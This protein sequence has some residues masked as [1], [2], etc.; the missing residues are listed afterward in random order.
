MKIFK[1]AHT[2]Y[3][4]VIIFVFFYFFY[5]FNRYAF[6]NNKEIPYLI[7]FGFGIIIIVLFIIT[8]NL[9]SLLNDENKSYYR[10]I[11]NENFIKNLLF[12]LMILTIF[13]PPVSFSDTIIGWN[14]ISVLNYF[15]GFTILFGSAFIPGICIYNLTPNPKIHELFNINPLIIKLSIYPLISFT[16]L[17]AISLI[18]DR[19]GLLAENFE[20]V[21]FLIIFFLFLL[22]FLKRR[23]KSNKVVKNK[24]LIK[25]N[26]WLLFMI[27]FGCTI[28]ALG[29]HISSQY[30]VPGDSWNAVV[31]AN[32]IGKGAPA[33]DGSAYYIYWGYIT[34]SL[35]ILTGIPY[36]NINVMLIS[37]IYLFV[38]LVYILIK[39]I[40]TNY[41]DI[42]AILA[43][44]FVITYSGL[45][46][47]YNSDLETTSWLIFD[48]I[49]NF[50]YKSFSVN[51]FLFSLSLFIV[52]IKNYQKFDK[53][54]NQK[55]N[56][57]IIFFV[58]FF[59][60][61]SYMIY[62]IPL[63][64]EIIFIVLF[65][66][67][68]KH[69]KNFEYV[70]LFLFSITVLFTF[71][72]F[73][74]YF[75]FSWKAITLTS[76][77]L[78]IPLYA[79]AELEITRRFLTGIYSNLFLI[80]IFILF[81]C[82][83]FIYKRRNNSKNYYQKKFIH[84][85]KVNKILGYSG[86]LIFILSLCIEL[87]YIL[88]YEIPS[89]ILIEP[90]FLYFFV[91]V[92][93][94]NIGIAGIFGLILSV[95]TFR[96][97][98][99]IFQILFVWL[100]LIFLVSSSLIFLNWIKYPLNPPLEI[101][102]SEYGLMM[103][104]FERNWYY[105]IIPISIFLSIGL[106]N[107]K[108]VISEKRIK[109]YF[110]FDIDLIQKITS[111]ILISTLIFFTFTN[112][113]IS[114]IYWYNR[115]NASYI[116]N[117]EAQ[118]YGYLTKNVP[119]HSNIVSD[120][121]KIVNRLN[122]LQ[123]WRTYYIYDQ[124]ENMNNKEI[125]FSYNADKNC[126]LEILE[127]FSGRNNIIYMY[128]NNDDGSISLQILFNSSRFYGSIELLI[129]PTDNNTIL[130][131]GPSDWSFD[132]INLMSGYFRYW[133][134]SDYIILQSYEPF[135]WY[136]I[137]IDFEYSNYG[138]KGLSQYK[139]QVT[140]NNSV[141]SNLN[142]IKNPESI[143]GFRIETNNLHVDESYYI[144]LINFS[145]CTNFDIYEILKSFD[146]WLIETLVRQ[147]IHYFIHQV[148]IEKFNEI[149][150]QYFNKTLYEYGEYVLCK[151]E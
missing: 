133:N 70:I 19:I 119:M 84:N 131:M 138:Y 14:Q 60:L 98:K 33:T 36:I 86:L 123:F 44:I 120:N 57:H 128:D 35:R 8:I 94:L 6:P 135:N 49:F 144:D 66:I 105:S 28:I 113:I 54:N 115:K 92:I 125:S 79:Q 136:R 51:L 143:Y 108:R 12:S 62:F 116:D 5:I 26:L 34:F 39:S 110:K 52:S 77:F 137:L 48:G 43:T 40:L 32:L 17:G 64:P 118:I 61:Q 9:K 24:I 85:S 99:Q 127:N 150:I 15:R 83:Y 65:L 1:K 71:F 101:P 56:F 29:L 11:L 97:N 81:S 126:S 93:F 53:K 141:Y 4:Y 102:K 37:F 76:L 122:D 21:L 69:R 111:L 147:E 91:N 25:R 47:I 7:I 50:R 117:D 22:D 55:R 67:I 96:L 134:G 149:I 90:N 107:F 89:N 27:A 78:G 75:F 18:L 112:T 3:I 151:S 72:D 95:F 23:L 129:F 38:F 80:G 104:W 87:V 58:A 63:I 114:G 148:K 109:K 30:L 2:Y 130:W 31:Y 10:C 142:M 74:S 132:G 42:Y 146:Q 45:F 82:F 16:M 59:T 100:I 46:Y 20:L 139:W 41:K 106:I 124:I 121:I 140:I 145:W 68:F 103:I 73:F 13:I 88:F